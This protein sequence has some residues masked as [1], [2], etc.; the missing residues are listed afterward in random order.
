MAQRGG[1]AGGT[2]SG[3]GGVL[4]PSGLSGYV[5]SGGGTG[6]GTVWSGVVVVGLVVLPGGVAVVPDVSGAVL[7]PAPLVPLVL[8]PLVSGEVPDGVVAAVSSRLQPPNKA[9]IKAAPNNAFDKFDMDFMVTPRSRQSCCR[10]SCLA[11]GEQQRVSSPVMSLIGAHVAR[12]RLCK[13]DL[14]HLGQFGQLPQLLAMRRKL[15]HPQTEE[16][17]RLTNGA[18]V[19]LK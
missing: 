19:S 8:V 13:L 15:E 4:V 17:A 6:V 1:V 7:V 9:A 10:C 18:T 5:L 14:A 3:F 12:I 2:V 11:A 16:A